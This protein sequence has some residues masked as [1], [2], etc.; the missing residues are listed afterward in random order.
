MGGYWDIAKIS[1]GVRHPTNKPTRGS[2][3]DTNLHDE[4]LDRRDKSDISDRSPV[5]VESETVQRTTLTIGEVLEEI[6]TPNTGAAI[7][8]ACYRRG[9][10]TKENAMRWITCAIMHR[11]GESFEGWEVHVPAVE[12]AFE[13]WKEE[14]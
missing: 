8:A 2:V 1:R 13:R 7:Q 6:N 4:R 11:R 10:I 14:S 3:R 9:E 12:A 5:R